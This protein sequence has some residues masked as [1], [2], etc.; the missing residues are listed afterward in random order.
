MQLIELITVTGKV[1]KAK[2]L[3]HIKKQEKSDNVSQGIYLKFKQTFFW[4]SG[5]TGMHQSKHLQTH[6][7]LYR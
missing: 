5:I 7:S 1:I 6:I 2:L 4:L 3:R